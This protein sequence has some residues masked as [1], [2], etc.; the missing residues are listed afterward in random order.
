VRRSPAPSPDGTGL[1]G[2]IGESYADEVTDSTGLPAPAGGPGP[3]VGRRSGDLDVRDGRGTVASAEPSTAP[4]TAPSAEP[5]TAPSAGP[6]GGAPAGTSAR[7]PDEA[8]AD[9]PTEV[10][11]GGPAPGSPPAPAAVP[12]VGPAV[13]AADGHRRRRA[14]T[15]ATLVLL[16][17]LVL[18]L[19]TS[20]VHL[21]RTSTAWED[22]AGAYL[23]D[24]R[25]LGEELATTRAALDGTESELEGVRAQLATAQGRI[26]ELADEKA[27]IGD[28]R[29]VQ[30]QLVD[31]QQRV[32]EAAGQVA[33]ALDQCVQG[34]Q[35][36]IG[37]LQNTVTGAA[38]YDPA[39]LERFRTD[40]E[41]L[42]QTASEANIA[43]QR[44]LSR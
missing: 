4:S 12:V 19:A 35:E 39:E 17:L 3:D 44:E 15:T 10:S 2:R 9:P 30:R 36:L 16:V 26:V 43:L 25:A 40:V 11:P 31:Y 13:P 23:Q 5:S 33:L 20:T 6:A 22:R 7:A 28:D 21:Y 8:P 29:E 32:S 41:Q 38:L 27:Q 37:Y 42:C 14:V 24:A 34:Q 1:G 18:G